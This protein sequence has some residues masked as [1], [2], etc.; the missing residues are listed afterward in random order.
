MFK[1]SAYTKNEV[2]TWPIP[3]YWDALAFLAV[4][5][6]I[7][8]VAMGA[9]QMVS[10]FQV[11]QTTAISLD[12]SNLPNYALRTVLRLFIALGFSLLFT[13]IV[14]TLAAKNKHAERLII[15]IIDVLQ[16]APVL[17][18]LTITIPAFIMLFKGSMLGPECAAIF[19]VFTSQVWNMTLSFYQSMRTV[20]NDMREA[21]AV[22]RLSGWQRFWRIEV[23]FAMPGLLWN[24]MMSMSGS[25]F[26]VTASEA[27][28]L[29]SQNITLPGIGSYISLAI[30]QANV[31]AV[32]YAIIC[33]LLVIFLYDQLLFRPLVYWSE[34]FKGEQDEEGK[35]DSYSL[36]VSLFQNTQFLRHSGVWL[37]VL[38]DWFVNPPFFRRKKIIERDKPIKQHFKK[39]QVVVFYYT[40][41]GLILL[42]ASILTVRFLLHDITLVELRHV[43]F[44]GFC[45]GLRVMVL[46]GISSLIWLPIGVWIGMRPRVAAK[47]QPLVQFLAAFPA[48]L[49]FPLVAMLFLKYKMNVEIWVAPLMVL[50]TQWYILFNV[51]AGASALPKD[52]KQVASLLRVKGWLRWRRFILPGVAPYFITGA[53]TAAGGAWNASILAEVIT[54]HNTKLQATGLGAYIV[55]H[56]TNGDTS[57]IILGTIIMCLFVLVINRIFWR[58]LYNIAVERYSIES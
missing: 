53:I 49:L 1:D 4:C 56:Y 28:P 37:S 9:H 44:L 6:I 58:P 10:P 32:I 20:P 27:F 7:I 39:K 25:W 34:R 52:L 16:S 30:T 38:G 18:F 36:V 51:I 13:F 29:G 2:T 5:G 54:W 33:M 46:I 35:E 22:F 55:E 3:N 8:A 50:G 45:T 14:G 12:P 17:S 47:I 41:L 48:N 26:F 42:T 23:P 43:I 24:M 40:T 15:P 11:G 31:H 19:A 57:K 21:S